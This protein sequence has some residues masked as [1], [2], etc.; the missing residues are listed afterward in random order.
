LIA[1][2][3]SAGNDSY[4]PG[5]EMRFLFFKGCQLCSKDSRKNK[6][7]ELAPR[8]RLDSESRK[9]AYLGVPI[10]QVSKDSETTVIVLLFLGFRSLTSSLTCD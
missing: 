2:K 1:N 10:E 9:L 3:M 4:F 6:F 8:F 5:L 7:P